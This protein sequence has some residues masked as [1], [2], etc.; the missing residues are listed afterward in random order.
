MSTSKSI[1][2]TRID[3]R[4][5]HGQIVG[6]WAGCVGANL[7]VVVDDKVANNEVEK[8]VMKIAAQS[9]GLDTRFFTVEKTINTISKA[10][11]SQKILLI[12]RTPATLHKLIEGGVDIDIVNIGNM[13]FSEGKKSIS[14]K[15]YVDEQDLEDLNYIKSKVKEIYIRDTPNS[16]KEVF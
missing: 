12:C 7:L 15:V 2:L 5:I 11:S 8:S 3:N 13:H 4:L 6:D 1:V 14:E 16:K 9:L 10:S